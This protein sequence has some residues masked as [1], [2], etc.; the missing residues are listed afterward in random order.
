M[1]ILAAL[2]A[3]TRSD[4]E[5]LGEISDALLRVQVDAAGKA[6]AVGYTPEEVAASRQILAEFLE[7]LTRLITLAQG[8]QLVA[9]ETHKERAAENI[10]ASLDQ[11]GKPREDWL[12]DITRTAQ[13]LHSNGR[14]ETSDWEL[15]EKVVDVLD[16]ELAQDLV[17]LSKA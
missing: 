10:L 9:A 11:Q 5:L 14:I 2:A 1:S 16:K 8:G 12:E 13:R 4:D 17:A 7:I 3:K 15:L 6:E